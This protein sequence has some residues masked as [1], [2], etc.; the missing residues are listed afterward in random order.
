MNSIKRRSIGAVLLLLVA[1]LWAGG[2][3]AEERYQ[4]ADAIGPWSDES[5][6]MA[7]NV[8]DV[9]KLVKSIV[10]SPLLA[11]DPSS[12]EGIQALSAVNAMYPVEGFAFG[13]GMQKSVLRLQL[14]V[15]VGPAR[16]DLLSRIAK[17]AMISEDLELLTQFG[18][19]VEG[20][21][22]LEDG[23]TAYRVPL[24]GTPFA[25]HFAAQGNLFLLGFRPEDLQES[26]AALK[27]PAQRFA[28]QRHFPDSPNYFL[29]RDNGLLQIALLAA[30]VPYLLRDNVLM[31]LSCAVKENQW[32]L[33][34]FTNLARA[35][36]SPKALEAFK[37]LSS[38][39]PLLGG[40]KVLG[41]F[42]F[43]EDYD[44]LKS[45]LQNNPDEE[46]RDGFEEFLQGV[47][48]MGLSEETLKSLLT[49]SVG[50]VLGGTASFASAPLP[51]AYL[52]F[53][54]QGDGAKTVADLL[55]KTLQ[56]Q[57]MPL[58]PVTIPGWDAVY[59]MPLPVTLT[60]AH[61]GST[62]LV[63][64][65][66]ANQLATPAEGSPRLQ[67]LQGDA[68]LY[69]YLYIDNE[70]L[71]KE[72]LT[73]LKGADIWRSILEDGMDEVGAA[74]VQAH[75]FIAT[76]QDLVVKCSGLEKG[77]IDLNF[78]APDGAQEAEWEKMKGSWGAPQGEEP[79]PASN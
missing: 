66:D 65:L 38:P 42:H 29:F 8:S 21:L 10:E 50:A 51:G 43:S 57:E 68:S 18:V 25:L 67:E 4:P 2:A 12:Q 37:S 20:P 13:V 58:A 5:F 6:H 45:V 15:S 77:S 3:L 71:Q 7:G 22:S 17:G 24:E 48:E 23:T 26:V 44:H 36:F 60:I 72:L 69:N 79:K 64:L 52:V 59:G 61:R 19:P 11:L 31:E 41:A 54:G 39:L 73:F 47:Q 9:Q 63:G 40:G 27:D 49:G 75:A 78:F 32:S 74:I 33:G 1:A 46:V 56:A 53:E 14:A 70:A 16:A 55:V 62:L 35:L 76:V 34:I 30:E 28:P